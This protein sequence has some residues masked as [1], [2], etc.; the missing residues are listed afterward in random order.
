MKH[1]RTIILNFLLYLRTRKLILRELRKL[2]ELEYK[3]LI[4][5]DETQQKN[6]KDI[7]LYSWKNVPYYR[8]ILEEANVVKDGKVDL[9]NFHRIKPLTKEIIKENFDSLITTD[10]KRFKRKMF[11]KTSGG[12]T[13]VPIKL[14]QDQHYRIKA[15]ATKWLFFSF[16]TDFPCKHILLWGSERDIIKSKSNIRSRIS[17]FL[18]Q[19][20]LL[21][22]FLM[23]QKNMANFIEKIN[24]FQPLIIESYVQSIYSLANYVKVNELKVHSPI[25]II[26]TAGTLYPD[27]KNSIE[28]IFDCSVLNRYGSREVGDV[29]CSC[30]KNQGLHVNIINNYM[31]ILDDEMNPIEPGELGKIY[32]TKLNNY[33][34]PLIRY[35]IGDLGIPSE[36]PQCDCGRGFPLIKFIEGREMSVFKTKEGTIVPAEFFIHFVGVVFNKGIISQFQVVQDDYDQITIKYIL[37]KKTGFQ[38]YKNE[39]SKSIKKVMGENCKVNWEE[40]EDIPTLPSGKYLYTFSK[41]S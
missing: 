26:T 37:E 17:N 14:I 24:E 18:Q 27:M 8:S 29:A 9:S 23:T 33:S 19:K 31:E 10:K 4:E 11:I 28:E 3:T 21:N 12:S 5:N 2:K 6:L 25:G 36:K 16:I 13:G 20:L 38:D 34:M 22:S 39:I 7:L 40:V 35:E 15:T 1:L 32:I 30:D 41:V